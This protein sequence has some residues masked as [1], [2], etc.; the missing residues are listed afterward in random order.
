MEKRKRNIEHK[1]RIVNELEEM[2]M[3]NE[4]SCN[5]VQEGLIIQG[6]RRASS[7]SALSSIPIEY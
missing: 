6:K 1:H 3:G 4:N 5:P 7:S 2:G